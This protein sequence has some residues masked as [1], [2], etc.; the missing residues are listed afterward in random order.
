M[1]KCAV[2]CHKE[3]DVS[4]TSRR[5]AFT[6]CFQ[7]LESEATQVQKSEV[8]YCRGGLFFS[9]S[10]FDNTNKRSLLLMTMTVRNYQR[11]MDDNDDDDDGDDGGTPS[12]DPGSGF[13]GGGRQEQGGGCSFQAWQGDRH[14]SVD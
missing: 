6:K 13:V 14:V 12:A 8:T 9:E 5:M 11:E 10:K 3:P 1:W 4:Q 2:L 7:P